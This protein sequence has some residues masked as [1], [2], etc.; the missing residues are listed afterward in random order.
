MYFFLVSLWS[1]VNLSTLNLCSSVR[2]DTLF[3]PAGIWLSVYICDVSYMGGMLWSLPS[4]E[5]SKRGYIQC[6]PQVTTGQWLWPRICSFYL[7]SFYL[8]SPSHLD[9]KF[10]FTF[11]HCFFFASSVQYSASATVWSTKSSILLPCC[12]FAIRGE[13]AHPHPHHHF[14]RY[15]WFLKSHL[16]WCNWSSISCYARLLHVPLASFRSSSHLL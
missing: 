16:F 6:I 3:A 13:K 1:W 7:T 12:Y 15:L 9:L 4:P 14:T 2:V 10:L 8:T 11:L 5:E